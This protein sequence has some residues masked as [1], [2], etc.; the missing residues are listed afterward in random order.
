MYATLKQYKE[1]LKLDNADKLTVQK[2]LEV[3]D[4]ADEGDIVHLLILGYGQE[5][6]QAAE[7]D[8]SMEC[9]E[10]DLA[11]LAEPKTDRVQRE[12][13]HAKEILR[14]DEWKNSSDFETTT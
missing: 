2:F 7:V 12:L 14:K 5:C 11:A 3:I 13:E 1:L 10:A 9:R 8:F 4:T 6:I